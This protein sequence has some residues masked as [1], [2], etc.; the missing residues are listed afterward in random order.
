MDTMFAWNITKCKSFHIF[1]KRKNKIY[2]NFWIVDYDLPDIDEL[3]ILEMR[4]K[5]LVKTKYFHTK[6]EVMK[7][8]HKYQDGEI[9]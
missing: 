5:G 4:N 9:K 6:K 1:G 2:Y 8:L 7:F 3:H